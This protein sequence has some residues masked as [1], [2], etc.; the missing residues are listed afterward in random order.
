MADELAV[1]LY[2]DRVAVIEQVRG[3]SRLAYTDEALS[4][5]DLGTLLLSLSPSG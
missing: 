2:G 4:R 1:W 3:R 5:Y